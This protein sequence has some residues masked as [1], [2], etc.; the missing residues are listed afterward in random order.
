MS[1]RSKTHILHADTKNFSYHLYMILSTNNTW[2]LAQD[3]FC[4]MSDLKSTTCLWTSKVIMRK[5]IH[6]FF[7][8]LV[9]IYRLYA[10][11]QD[12]EIVRCACCMSVNRRVNYRHNNARPGAWNSLP[13]TGSP[14]CFPNCLLS[15]S[16]VF[17]KS[18]LAQSVEGFALCDG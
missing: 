7:W 17:L 4:T 3:H 10:E 9:L 16:S 13:V 14:L 11:N 1:A 6:S 8:L 5:S 2:N 12:Q 15:F 18:V